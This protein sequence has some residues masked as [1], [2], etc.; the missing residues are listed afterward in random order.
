MRKIL[1]VLN[2]L[3]HWTV[4]IIVSFYVFFRKTN[5]YDTVYFLIISFLIVSWTLTGNE[6]II[7]YFE[8][9]CI[10]PEYSFNSDPS[11]PYIN[12][13]FGDLSVFVTPILFFGTLY[14]LYTMLT[15]YKVPF[16]IKCVLLY[17]TMYRI[18]KFRLEEFSPEIKAYFQ[19]NP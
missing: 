19:K 11:L 14:T 8:K 3:L 17:F 7:S 6:C 4:S 12:L 5:K 16:I 2:M 15:I 10:D 1:L 18:V 13:I 9:L